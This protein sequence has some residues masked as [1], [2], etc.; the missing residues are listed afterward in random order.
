MAMGPQA[1]AEVTKSLSPAEQE[2]IAFAIARLEHVPAELAEAV[3]GEWGQL[4][5]AM[6][7]ISEGGVEY[8]RQVLEAAVGPQKA[9]TIL[10]RV[11]SQLRDKAGFHNLRNA[12]AAQV[13]ALVRNE[14]PQTIALLLAHLE[15]E[16]TAAVLK[17]LPTKLG[18]EVLYRLAKMEKV[19]PEVLQ[20][21][22]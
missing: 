9:A 21:L 10:R 4:E 6:H 16:Q 1:A 13:T 8:A 14:H 17:E 3:I 20:V 19:L 15:P 18:G 12:D 22:E 2:E 11:E 5:T 7:S